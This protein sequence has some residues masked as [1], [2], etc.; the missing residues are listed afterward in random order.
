[1]KR[2]D[3]LSAILTRLQT[4][5]KLIADELAERFGVSTRTIYRDMQSLRESG[6]PLIGEAGTGYSLVEGYRVPPVSFTMEELVTF[7]MAEKV[8]EKYTEKNFCQRFSS[9][10]EKITAVLR[11]DQKQVINRLDETVV[12][13]QHGVVPGAGRSDNTLNTVLAAIHTGEV[14]DMQYTAT[15]SNQQT[16]RKIEPVGIYLFFNQWYL[17]A[18]CRLRSDYRVFRT[19]QIDRIRPTGIFCESK[20]PG[21]QEYIRKMESEKQLTR[22]VIKTDEHL[23]KWLHSEKY[24]YGLV[25]ETTEAGT[26][27]MTFMVEYP[28]DIVRWIMSFY[29]RVEILYPDGLD[30]LIR[31]TLNKMLSQKNQLPAT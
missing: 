29:D 15:W 16:Q 2:L 27:E 3:R 9:A 8:I 20:H 24:N 1:M 7:K 30:A 18:W 14:L 17:V 25:M 12:I 19:D 10:L 31:E 4:G 22:V 6:V 26:T 23:A 5:R 28:H 21:L 11:Q 13:R